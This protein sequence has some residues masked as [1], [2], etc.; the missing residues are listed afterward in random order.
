MQLI[1][2]LTINP[3]AES[4]PYC[5]K[6]S[7]HN[8]VAALDEKSRT[9]ITGTSSDGRPTGSV[10]FQSGVPSAQ[11]VQKTAGHALPP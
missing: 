10:I 5:L 4:A 11:E 1:I 2:I 6:M 3:E 7:R 9:I 8:P